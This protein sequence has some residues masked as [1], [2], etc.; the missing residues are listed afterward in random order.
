MKA[1]HLLAVG[2]LAVAVSDARLANAAPVVVNSPYGA[3]V[4]VM[5]TLGYTGGQNS[6]VYQRMSDMHCTWFRLSTGPSFSSND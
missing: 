4:P 1:H 2:L 6:V 3:S 5:I